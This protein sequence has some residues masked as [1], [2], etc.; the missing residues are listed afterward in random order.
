MSSDLSDKERWNVIENYF[1][2]RDEE[3]TKLLKLKKS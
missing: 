2:G 3:V 1:L